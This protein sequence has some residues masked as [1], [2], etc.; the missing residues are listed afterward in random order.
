MRSHERSRRQLDDVSYVRRSWWAGGFKEGFVQFSSRCL[1]LFYNFNSFIQHA[2]KRT[3]LNLK[4][5][6]K[7]TLSSHDWSGFRSWCCLIER[8]FLPPFMLSTLPIYYSIS[9]CCCC[10]VVVA[11]VVFAFSSTSGSQFPLFQ[12][13]SAQAMS[14][15]AAQDE[16]A[17]LRLANKTKQT[18]LAYYQFIY[19]SF[20]S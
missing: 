13:L 8:L 3:L 5:K 6:Q 1:S 19:I 14:L 20:P 11:V 9:C 15:A 4:L 18:I 7:S 12:S 17:F 2:N 16:A 10:Y